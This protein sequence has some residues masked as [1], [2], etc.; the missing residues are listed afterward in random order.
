MGEI[1]SRGQ[2]RMA[3]L[4]WAL[5][6]VPAILLLGFISG[7]VANSGYG[8]RWFALLRKP[9]VMPPAITFPIAWTVFYIMM[10]LALALVITAR[11]A[12]LRGLAIALFLIQLALNLAWSP[13]FFGAHQV[14]LA[15]LVLIVLFLAAAGAS[16]LFSLIRP[17]AGALMI[18]Y[19][20]WLLFAA[21]LTYQI[22]QLNPGAATLAPSGA[23][24]QIK[25]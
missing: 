7:R 3:V 8:N 24:T 10:G 15:L 20:L 17:V 14:D 11:G 4:R 21:Y 18:P 13:I 25:L 23:S 12:R 5:F 16:V 22:G 1:A 2:L 6:V 19:L 9:D